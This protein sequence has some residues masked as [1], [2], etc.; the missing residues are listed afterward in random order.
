MF[1][2]WLMTPYSLCTFL[3]T[4]LTSKN[5][6]ILQKENKVHE[7]KLV[8]GYWFVIQQTVSFRVS[9]KKLIKVVPWFPTLNQSANDFLRGLPSPSSIV[10]QPSSINHHQPSS[11]NHHQPSINH[12][13]PSF[14]QQSF[15]TTIYHHHHSLTHGHLD[16]RR[17][18]AF[19]RTCAV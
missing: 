8:I 17:G 14:C 6:W 13:Q 1:Y 7:L 5:S 10:Y 4:T 3:S 9:Q 11:I 15:S 18:A 19:C 2:P 16:R 12:H